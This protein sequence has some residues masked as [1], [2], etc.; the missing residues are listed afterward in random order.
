[1][2]IEC[3]SHCPAVPSTDLVSTPSAITSTH[4]LTDPNSHLFVP[5]SRRLYLFRVTYSLNNDLFNLLAFW[6]RSWYACTF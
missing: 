1:M 2:I 3:Q 6:K 4:A 5:P